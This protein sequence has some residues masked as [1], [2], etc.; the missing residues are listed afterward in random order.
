MKNISSFCVA[1]LTGFIG[2]HVFA[3]DNGPLN[4]ELLDRSLRMDFWYG[5]WEAD[6]TKTAYELM[7]SYRNIDKLHLAAGFG[8]AK[9]A[10]YDRSKAYAGGY[11]F[12][13][14]K[15]YF[16]TFVTQ[17]KYDYPVNPATLTVN[18]DSSSYRN[19]PKLDM[20]LSHQ[21]KQNL[22][23]RLSYE[24]SRPDFF[25]DPN[26]TVTNHKLGAE[27]YYA[28]AIPELRTRL[29][30]SVLHD[31][32]P[33]K[34]EIKG[35]DNPLTPLGA[36]TVT[37]VVYKTTSLFGGAVEYVEGKWEAEA[38]LLENR[39][40][41]NSYNYSLINKF[42][43]RINDD[44]NLR[45]DYLHDKFSNQSHFSGRT[46]NVYL[47]SYYQQYSPVLK[48]GVGYKHIGLPDRS[49]DTAFVF[50]QYKTGVTH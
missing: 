44:R 7:A 27:L 49:N 24:I 32:D 20:E 13:Q 12:Y 45:L 40:L 28:T 9:Q 48:Y 36:A 14:D 11:Y 4:Q 10:Y 22:L 8:Q 34:T 35:R 46:A 37:T 33:N 2:Q 29:Y 42:I 3:A 16:R 41:D 19:E 26:T 38:K 31:P 6:Y 50:L 23:G 15:S 18:P 39:D 43:Y 5:G 1:L 17:K 30:A 21:L 25:H 47:V